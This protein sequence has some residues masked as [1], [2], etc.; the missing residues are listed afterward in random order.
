MKR[1][2]TKS[3]VSVQPTKMG[4]PRAFDTETAINTAMDLFW[5]FGYDA[6]TSIMLAEAMGINRPSLQA[7][8]GSKDDLFRT[9][10]R[11]YAEGPSGY[12]AI[13]LKIPDTKTAIRAYLE[14]AA[15][16]TTSKEDRLGCLITLGAT[17][18]AASSEPIREETAALRKQ[19]E[20]ALRK[21]LQQGQSIG[22]IKPD[23]DVPSLASFLITFLYGNAIRAKEGHSRKELQRTIELMLRAI[24]FTQVYTLAR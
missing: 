7:A 20:L 15:D 18:G 1:G 16:N 14:G 12:V 5:R 13:A 21:R 11:H 24:P 22:D 10:L 23:A 3:V 9:V 8:F 6:V 17:M 2:A 19:A 4:R